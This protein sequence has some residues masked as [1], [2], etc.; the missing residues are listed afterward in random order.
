MEDFSPGLKL[1]SGTGLKFCSDY[2]EIFSLD[3]KIFS[4]V[5]FWFYIAE[6]W[7]ACLK[8][9]YSMFLIYVWAMYHFNDVNSSAN[10]N[11]YYVNAILGPDYLHLPRSENDMRKNGRVILVTLKLSSIIYYEAQGIKLNVH[12]ED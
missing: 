7:F 6:K 12:L 5:L 3:L 8:K 11:N 1:Q 10:S 4:S 9:K 2:M